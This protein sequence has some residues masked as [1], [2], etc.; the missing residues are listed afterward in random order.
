M[1]PPTVI[2]KLEREPTLK[3]IMPFLQKGYR[4]FWKKSINVLEVHWG[5]LDLF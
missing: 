3:E 5:N 4:V 2:F 1:E